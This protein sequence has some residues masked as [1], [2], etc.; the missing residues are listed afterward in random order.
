MDI[1]ISAILL[2]SRLYEPEPKKK[3]KSHKNVTWPLNLIHQPYLTKN[4]P[5]NF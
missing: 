1:A 4:L 2:M 5:H 3:I